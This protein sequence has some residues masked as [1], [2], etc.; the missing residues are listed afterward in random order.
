MQRRGPSRIQEEIAQRRPFASSRQE[1]LVGLLRTSDVVRRRLSAVIEPEGLTL[2][3]YNVL[4]IL[5]GAGPAG[6]PTLEIA[7]RM[8]ERAP[9]ITRLLERLE[10][11][12][13][14]SR[15]RS[16]SDQRQVVCRV[17][18]RGLKLLSK[19]D[20]PID[21]ANATS[22]GDLGCEEVEQLILLL[23]GVRRE[24]PP[25]SNPPGPDGRAGRH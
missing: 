25:A 15:R 21:E 5:R 19:L 11:K 8:L 20:G 7:D 6:L 13:V 14:I 23:D 10:R 24:A 16:A 17:T 22:L 9:G 1:C 3:Q 18:R 4:R 2:Q 12:E